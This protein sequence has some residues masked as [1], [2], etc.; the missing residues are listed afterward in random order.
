MVSE[1]QTG[2]SCDHFVVLFLSATRQHQQ[3]L[4]PNEGRTIYVRVAKVFQNRYPLCHKLHSRK[5]DIH[6]PYTLIVFEMESWNGL[7]VSS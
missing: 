6:D 4:T 1:D 3:H 5:I 7:L 2:K